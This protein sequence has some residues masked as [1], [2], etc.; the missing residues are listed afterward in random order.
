[1]KSSRWILWVVLAT[2]LAGLHLIAGLALLKT[3]FLPL[4]YKSLGYWQPVREWEDF[5]IQ[6]V[7]DH[8]ALDRRV[9]DG[10]VILLGDSIMAGVPAEVVG[11][12]A[13][14]FGLGGDTTRVL[15]R[16]MP[17]LRS[18]DRGEAVVIEVGVN[19][20]KYR[21]PAETA[22]LYSEILERIPPVTLV[23]ALSVLPVDETNPVVARRSDLRNA[24][25]SALNDAI[26]ATCQRRPNCRYLDL[27]PVV[28][29]TNRGTPVLDNLGTDGWHLSVQGGERIGAWIR[30]M[31]ENDRADRRPG[32]R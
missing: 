30:N 14:N 22:Y 23:I 2:Y 27:W 29:D 3:N 1:M 5:S 16:R 19:D 28:W 17:V 24:A 12:N 15:L 20:L 31:L 11:P 21:T 6:T 32:L 8:A 26:R 13:V 18:I 4:V 9:P 7:L 10:A 25:I